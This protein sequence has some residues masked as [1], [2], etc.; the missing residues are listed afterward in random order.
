[1]RRMLAG[2]MVFTEEQTREIML[3]LLGMIV[4]G[5]T[6]LVLVCIQ[7]SRRGRLN[8]RGRRSGQWAPDPSARHDLRYHDGHQWTKHVRDAGVASVDPLPQVAPP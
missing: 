5:V 8:K 7:L 2:P 6:L 3:T 4:L 1:M